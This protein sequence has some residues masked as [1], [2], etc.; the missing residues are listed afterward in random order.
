[1]NEWF[2]HIDY[3]SNT[4]MYDQSVNFGFTGDFTYIVQHPSRLR[5]M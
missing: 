2:Y 5:L 1:M 4:T 3:C